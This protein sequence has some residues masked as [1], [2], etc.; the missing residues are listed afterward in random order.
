MGEFYGATEVGNPLFNPRIVSLVPEIFREKDISKTN[1]D[2][3]ARAT[4]MC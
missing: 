2:C 4:R 3:D 1:D